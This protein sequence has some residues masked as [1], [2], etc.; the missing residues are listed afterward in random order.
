VGE[1]IGSIDDFVDGSLFF[2]VI[3]LKKAALAS[4]TAIACAGV[5]WSALLINLDAVSSA[6]ALKHRRV[7]FQERVRCADQPGLCEIDP[8]GSER[9]PAHCRNCDRRDRAGPSRR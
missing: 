7:C 5:C 3:A 9:D 8:R 1:N 4:L 6:G 2:S